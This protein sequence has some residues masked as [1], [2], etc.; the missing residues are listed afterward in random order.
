MTTTATTTPTTTEA[1]STR[2]VRPAVLAALALTGFAQHDEITA[3]IFGDGA[4]QP[5][6]VQFARPLLGTVGYLSLAW[7]LSRIAELVLGRALLRRGARPPRLLFEMIAA[8]LFVTALVAIAVFVF[9]GSPAGALATSGVLVAILGFAL[10][11]TITD[12]FSGLALSMESPFR[13]GDWIE[14]ENGVSGKVVEMTWR[15]TRIET[16]DRVRVILP[17]GRL[18][19]G[20]VTNY[21]APRRH[22][23]IQETVTLDPAVPVK[24]AKQVL[25]DAA[26]AAKHIRRSP[27]PD[28]RVRGFTER[29]TAYVV[30][31]WVPSHAD[32]VD[33]RD[34]VLESIDRHLR[35]SGIA[36][37]HARGCWPVDHF[38]QHPS[39]S[40]SADRGHLQM[41]SPTR[42]GGRASA[43]AMAR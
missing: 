20:R 1:P 36:M 42:R 35:F 8:L 3:L 37:A 24:R 2:F 25:L 38:D 39:L 18:A 9:D 16:R 21:S 34:A 11:N 10:R 17:N 27:A 41:A 12:I 32:A 13:I 23:R 14:T 22:Y 29:G 43:I 40:T 19:A 15:A 7:L 5:L 26:M 31:Y 6:A 4:L 33:C 30:R 28:V